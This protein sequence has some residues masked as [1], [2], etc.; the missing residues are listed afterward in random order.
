MGARIV[1]RIRRMELGNPGDARGV[2][3][4]VRNCVR[5]TNSKNQTMYLLCF[6]SANPSPKGKTL[7]TKLAGAAAKV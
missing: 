2:G 3:Q 7:A 6:A 1:A 5:L 4:G